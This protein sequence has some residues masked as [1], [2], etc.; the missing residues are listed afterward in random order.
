MKTSH[1]DP[2]GRNKV[3]IEPPKPV[4][5]SIFRPIIGVP[6]LLAYCILKLVY[7]SYLGGWKEADRG[8]AGPLM[9][10]CF[11]IMQILAPIAVSTYLLHLG[12]WAVCV[13]LGYNALG[14]FIFFAFHLDKKESRE[15]WD[16]KLI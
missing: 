8:E 12:W 3:P 9:F 4:H 13:V 14:L 11:V 15:Y 1:E 10:V 7:F 2:Y 16:T 5:F 6:K